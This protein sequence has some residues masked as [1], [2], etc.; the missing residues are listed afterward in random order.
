MSNTLGQKRSAF[1]LDQVQKVE[2][3]NF[4]KLVAGLPAMILQNGF[5]QTLAF[6]LSK[7]T[8]QGRL[9]K[10]TSHYQ[11]Y[12]IMASWQTKLGRLKKMESPSDV[13]KEISGMPQ[14]DYLE[15][16]V[17]TLALLEWVKRYANADLFGRK[18]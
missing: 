5:G 14:S 4:D 6:L 16:Q 11:A 1:A 12:V 9:E 13:I 7:A 18:G 15:M 8:K 2:A 3:K 10:N 17:E